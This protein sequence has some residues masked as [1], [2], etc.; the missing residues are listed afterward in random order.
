MSQE[1]AE[2]AL[3]ANDIIRATTSS[4]DNESESRNSSIDAIRLNE[5]EARE[6]EKW[7]L[8]TNHWIPLAKVFD[9]GLPGPS[10]SESDT[11]LSRD[12]YVYKQNNL[13]HSSGSIVNSLIRYIL[14][15]IAFPD[16]SYSFVGFTGFAGRSIYPIVKQCYIEGGRPSTQNEIDC[17]MAALGFDKISVGRF[18][19]EYLE[20]FDL[21]P[22]NALKDITGD[23]FIIDAEIKWIK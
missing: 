17:Y 9:L 6:A 21:L 7:A 18:K 5:R 15:N 19:N 16:T 11:Y 22:K 4:R 10:G 3:I 2:L 13:L 12:G 8:R 23:I 1:N 20:L 14:H